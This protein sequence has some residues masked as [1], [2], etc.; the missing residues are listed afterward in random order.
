MPPILAR[1]F[2]LFFF[3]LHLFFSFSLPASCH[4]LPSLLPAHW[5]CLLHRVCL[6][7][8]CVCVANLLRFLCV[9]FASSLH[10]LPARC[11]GFVNSLR[12]LCVCSQLAS[13][14]L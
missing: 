1:F 8:H 12:L 4:L 2:F 7:A 3:L 6:P 5:V 11:V 10:L 14:S 9:C 13:R